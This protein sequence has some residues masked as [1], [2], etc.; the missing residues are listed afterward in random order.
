M[1]GFDFFVRE[2]EGAGMSGAGIYGCGFEAYFDFLKSD[3]EVLGRLVG[4]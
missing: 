2:R 4:A 3:L 1:I